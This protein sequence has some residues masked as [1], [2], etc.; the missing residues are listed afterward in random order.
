MSL[1]LIFKPAARFELEEAVGWYEE[2]QVGLGREFARE[3]FAVLERAQANPELFGRVRGRARKIRLR[4]F[5]KYS[6]Y[7]AIRDDTF[8]VVAVFHGARNP[9]KLRKRL[10]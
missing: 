8:A 3:V 10:T 2:Q 5:S 7:F 4:R 6:V 9:T 1:A